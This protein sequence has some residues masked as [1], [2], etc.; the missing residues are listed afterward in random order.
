MS[1]EYILD[2]ST[3]YSE[4]IAKMMAESFN[5]TK[6]LEKYMVLQHPSSPMKREALSPVHHFPSLHFIT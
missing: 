1:A 2:Q 3:L 4:S 6:T 5:L